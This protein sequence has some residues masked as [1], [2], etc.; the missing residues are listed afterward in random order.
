MRQVLIGRKK[1]QDILKK[2]L[3]SNRPEFVSII[4]RRR[5]GK[6]FLIQSIYEKHIAFELTG[7][8]HASRVEQL[9]NF[10]IQLTKQSKSPLPIIPPKNWLSA[11]FL[12]SEFLENKLGEEKIV[13]FLDELP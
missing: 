2:V 12:L 5:V 13:V 6:T 4:G 7:I 8:Q 11:F 1:E 3:E 9:Q 10:S